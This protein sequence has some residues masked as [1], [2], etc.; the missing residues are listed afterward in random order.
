MGIRPHFQL[1][2]GINNL[3]LKDNLIVDRRYK[4]S[5]ETGAENH[6]WWAE[7]KIKDLI[8]DREIQKPK[9]KVSFREELADENYKRFIKTNQDKN[10]EDLIIFDPENGVPEIVGILI[11]EIPYA[12][13]VTYALASVFPKM[14]KSGYKLIPSIVP[15]TS[16]NR[17]SSGTSAVLQALDNPKTTAKARAKLW[18]ELD[19]FEKEN[20]N[21]FRERIKNGQNYMFFDSYEFNRYSQEAMIIF[22]LIGLKVNKSDIKLMLYWQ[23]G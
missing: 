7:T 12:S 23:W 9:D 10:I 2:C 1:I 21:A 17:N 5:K 13:D 19:D 8:K 6:S 15:P 22:D 14:Q 20:V 3:K 11:D 16:K 18:A 4:H